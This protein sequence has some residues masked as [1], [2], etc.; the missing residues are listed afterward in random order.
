[1]AR[2]SLSPRFASSGYVVLLLFSVASLLLGSSDAARHWRETVPV[3][4]R[5]FE[6]LLDAASC[7]LL[8]MLDARFLLLARSSVRL[9]SST[10]RSLSQ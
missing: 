3:Q 10:F 1:M 9:T 4:P 7:L 8:L 2:C 6:L 5:R